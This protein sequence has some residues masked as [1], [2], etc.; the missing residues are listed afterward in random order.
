MQYLLCF[1]IIC[2]TI[3]ITLWF[4]ILFPPKTVIKTYPKHH[5]YSGETISAPTIGITTLSLPII[6]ISIW[7]QFIKKY[8]ISM[9]TA[10]IFGY[11]V[12]YSLTI[13]IVE[14]LKNVVGKPR[15]T[16]EDLCEPITELP[17]TINSCS[18]KDAIDAFR[19]FPSAHTAV[20]F[21]AI[22]YLAYIIKNV[23]LTGVLT[24]GGIC[25]ALTR[26]Y[27]NLHDFSDVGVGAIIGMLMGI[28]GGIFFEIR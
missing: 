16:F 25:V 13:C 24:I 22:G 5:K 10:L 15:P 14:L 9:I 12:I 8:N 3:A 11:V 2:I 17:W 23:S 27:D 28:F 20:A 19:S 7:S 26:I 18:N 1:S 6:I 21:V 4:P